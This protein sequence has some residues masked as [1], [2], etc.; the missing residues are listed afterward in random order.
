MA[1]NA[2]PFENDRGKKAHEDGVWQI[3]R[4]LSNFVT[5]QWDKTRQKL[6]SEQVSEE[7]GTSSAEAIDD[8]QPQA[9]CAEIA[10]DHE[11][12]LCTMDESTPRG[13]KVVSGVGGE[14]GWTARS[15][16]LIGGE[17]MP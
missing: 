6:D 10:K 11:F 13:R 1:I 3:D 14:D 12:L 5:F 17:A 16:D 15:R 7:H 2:A 4:N 9:S 8:L